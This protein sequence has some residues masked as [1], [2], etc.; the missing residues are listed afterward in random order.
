MALLKTKK[1]TTSRVEKMKEIISNPHDKRPLNLIV[2]GDLLISFKLAVI[3]KG[4]TM[5]EI[6]TKAMKEYVTQNTRRTI[7]RE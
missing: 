2:D 1:K 3:R 5:T 4:T 6:L 7:S